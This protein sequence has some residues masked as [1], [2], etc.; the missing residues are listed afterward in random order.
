[1]TTPHDPLPGICPLFSPGEAKPKPVKRATTTSSGQQVDFTPV[2]SSMLIALH[3]LAFL[4][5]PP[6]P[7]PYPSLLES[8]GERVPA[9][10]LVTLTAPGTLPVAPA[11]AFAFAECGG[12]M[13]AKQGAIKKI[14]LTVGGAGGGGGGGGGDAGEVSKNPTRNGTTLDP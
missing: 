9:P 11:F 12:C 8:S 14:K 1:M 13:F 3:L 2:C 6:Q 5:S 4:P 7:A 10:Q